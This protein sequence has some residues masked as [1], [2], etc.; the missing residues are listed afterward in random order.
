DRQLDWRTNE[1]RERQRWRNIVNSTL[2][3]VNNP[4]ACFDELFKHYSLPQ[5]WRL[6]EGTA[7]LLRELAVKRLTLGIASNY[8][9]RLRDVVAGFE[10]LAPVR[11]L[12][13]SS[14]VG[15]RK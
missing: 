9:R 11:H 3:D 5:A 13:I 14:E 15:Y 7:C 8:D 10:D 2:E 4:D 6:T 12:V 1:H